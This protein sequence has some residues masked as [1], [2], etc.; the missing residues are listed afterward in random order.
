MSRPPFSRRYWQSLLALDR[1]VGNAMQA[2]EGA[3]RRYRTS[4]RVV[5]AGA[6]A[7]FHL[8]LCE[9]VAELRAALRDLRDWSDR[10]TRESR[11]RA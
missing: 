4:S 5:A 2:Y 6:R 3:V 11:S 1:R 10:E 8:E 9:A 7:E